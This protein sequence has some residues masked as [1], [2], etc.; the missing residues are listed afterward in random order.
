MNKENIR[1]RFEE[2]LESAGLEIGMPTDRMHVRNVIFDYAVKAAYEQGVEDG[3]RH[4]DYRC[5]KCDT[6][7]EDY[8]K[9]I[10]NWGLCD[11]CFDP[12]LE[13]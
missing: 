1:K 3:F 11:K 4:A 12:P 5:P 10:V 13:K 7:I 8:T 6:V 9:H 2:L